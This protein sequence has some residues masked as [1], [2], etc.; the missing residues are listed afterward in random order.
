MMNTQKIALNLIVVIL[1]FASFKAFA[2]SG[3]PFSLPSATSY[4]PSSSL[5]ASAG[6]LDCIDQTMREQKSFSNISQL[7]LA[8]VFD[9]SDTCAKHGKCKDP[10]VSFPQDGKQGRIFAPIGRITP[11]QDIKDPSTREWIRG[12]KGSVFGTAFLVSPCH[13]MTNYHAIYGIDPGVG[14]EYSATF[15]VGKDP[16][17]GGRPFEIQ[18]LPVIGDNPFEDVA[19]RLEHKHQR[20]WVLLETKPCVGSRPEIGWMEL[21][22]G[23]PHDPDEPFV[24]FKASIAGFFGDLGHENFKGQHNC[25]VVGF[26]YR[27]GWLHGCAST[28]G[29]SGSP[30]FRMVDGIPKVFG[31]ATAGKDIDMYG[32]PSHVTHFKP[33]NS[34]S[35]VNLREIKNKIDPYIQPVMVTVKSKELN[36][37]TAPVTVVPLSKP[38]TRCEECPELVTIPEGSFSMG[39]INGTGEADEKP[40]RIVKV[41][42]FRLSKYEVTK[43]QFAAFMRATGYQSGESDAW[44]KGPNQPDL[45]TESTHPASCIS[46]EDAQAYIRW[47]NAVSGKAYRLPSESE[48]EYAARAGTTSDYPM[49]EELGSGKANC[50][51]SVCGDRFDYTSPVGSFAANRWGLHDMTGNVWEWV[52]DCWH[53]NYIGAPY[54]SGAWTSGECTSRVLRGGYCYGTPASL[55]SATRYSTSPDGRDHTNGFRLAHDL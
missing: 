41:K 33:I 52:Q 5:E 35:A 22:S 3:P 51:N 53:D 26:S 46:W 54:H 48:W 15:Y 13:I 47:L 27:S 28:P 12:A 37:K 21:D 23:A 19:D 50:D 34:N 11:N 14:P 36:R 49:G 43:A 45:F 32:E 30:L 38:A 18:A 39:D 8:Q 1:T 42:G 44:C 20:D 25:D 40:V 24:P 16:K 2:G 29:S 4:E 9:T 17:N 6:C 10:R 55:R 31:M 7:K